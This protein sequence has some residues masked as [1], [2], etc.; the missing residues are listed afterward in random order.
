MFSLHFSVPSQYQS[1]LKCGIQNQLKQGHLSRC[2][3]STSGNA[4]QN[5]QLFFSTLEIQNKLKQ[6]FAYNVDQ[7]YK[8]CYLPKF[9]M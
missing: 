5:D 8:G 6:E 4:K 7:G 2:F 1:L 3:H 9:Q